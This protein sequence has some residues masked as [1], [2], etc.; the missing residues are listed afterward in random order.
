MTLPAAI[1]IAPD[2][3]TRKV[4]DETVLLQLAQGSYYGLDAI[5]TRIWAL[6][7]AGKAPAQV[8]DAM[9]AEYDVVRAQ[10]EEDLEALLNELLARGL[11]R[12][13]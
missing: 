7:A 12:P 11:V 8:C 6:L 13:G 1:V 9:V 5:G 10:A 3:M 4:G 2:V